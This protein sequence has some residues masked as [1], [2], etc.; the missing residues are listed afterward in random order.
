ML[1]Q[2]DFYL[3]NNY[4][5]HIMKKNALFILSLLLTISISFAQQFSVTGVVTDAKTG[6]PIPGANVIEKNTSNGTVTDFDG[7]YSIEVGSDAI[8]VFSF[9]GM[10]TKEVA[11]NGNTEI[12]VT[13]D[14][15]TALLDE[16]VVVGYGTQK[17]VNLTGSISSIDSDDLVKNATSNVSSALAGR[18]SGVVTIQSSGEPGADIASINIRGLSSLNSNAPLIL[19]DGI[20]RSINSLNPNDIQS[21]S[22][23]KDAAAAAI[24]GMRASNGVI[25]VTTKR[26]G[27]T[28]PQLSVNMY[29]G[30]QVPTR[31]PDFLDSYNYAVLLNEANRND[32]VP[33]PYS[34]EDLEKYQSGSNPD[35]HPNTDWIGETLDSYSVMNSFDISVRGSYEKLRYY[36]SLGYLYQDG[37]YNNNNYK[38]FNFRSNIDVDIS[39]HINLQLD[40]SGDLENKNRPGIATSTLFSNIMRTP[41]T[42]VNQYSNG[43]YSIFSRIPP[44]NDGGYNNDEDFAFQSRIGLNIDIPFVEGLSVTA[45]VA[46]D[47]SAGGSNSAR[48]NFVGRN[49][50]FTVPTSYTVYDSNTG[51]FSISTPQERGETASLFESRAQG[52]QLTTEGIVNYAKTVGKHDI[53]AKLVYSRTATEYTTL[54]AG[55]TN[56]LGTSIDFFVAGDESTRTNSNATYETAILGYAGRLTYAYDSKYLFEFNGRYDGSYK[57]SD[58]GRFGF[59]PSFSMAWR[60]SEENFLKDSN[61]INNLKIRASYGELGSDDIAPFR[62]IE[63]FSFT[64]PFVNGGEVVKTLASNGIPDGATTW[65]KSKTYN[66]GIELGLWNNLF[67]LETDVFYK[68]TSD[69]LASPN[70][71]VPGTFGGSLPLQNIGIVDNKGIEFVLNHRNNVNDWDYF[72]SFNFSYAKNEVIDIAEADDVNPLIRRTGKSILAGT[73]IGYMASGLWLTQDE[74][75]AANANARTQT[76]NPAAVYQTQNPQPGDIRYVDINGDGVVNSEDRTIIGKG[77]VPEITFGLNLGFNYRQWDFSALFQGAANFDMYLSAEASWAFFNGGKVFDKHLDRAQI[78]PDGNVINTNADYPRLTLSNNAVNE[79]FS[80]YW[81]EAGDYVRFKNLEIG[82]TFKDNFVEKIG[83]DRLR[84][85]LNGRNLATWSAIKQLDPENPQQRGWF[86]PQQKVFSLGANI[87][88]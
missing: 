41:P 58:E 35:T 77:N 52:Y 44:I 10:Q 36:N 82:Y 8:L 17:K 4:Q 66:L 11:V 64:E 86:Y 38:R 24:Y 7:K 37:L 5:N 59:F 74:I 34:A 60:L 57:F 16:V 49:K 62:Y 42:E 39:N 54:S 83:M 43:G 12:N 26:G 48:N 9:V 70:L 71:E 47:R 53:G 13:L 55:R 28:K 40:F 73:R 78:G 33:E 27:S 1:L 32:G 19:V 85:Y 3:L 31:M 29:T 46:Y 30:A 80:S 69:I 18:M 63:V 2:V 88:L 72:A 21:I 61:L 6:E 51:E 14:E 45:Q 25:L 15:D 87:E 81:L 65:E 75:D 23:L 79:R 67:S 68:R 76:G 20:P 84:I 22:V 50:H 56:F